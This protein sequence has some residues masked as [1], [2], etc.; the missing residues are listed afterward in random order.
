MNNTIGRADV[1]GQNVD[2]NFITGASRP[3]CVAVDSRY[4]YWTNALGNTIG[5]A[6]TA[7]AHSGSR[8]TPTK[9]R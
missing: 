5:R 3:Y 6:D 1:N 9:P 2:Q 8:W 4:I 7:P